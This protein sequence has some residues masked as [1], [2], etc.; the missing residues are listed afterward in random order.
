M[1]KPTRPQRLRYPASENDNNGPGWSKGIVRLGFEME[2]D[3]DYIVGQAGRL[4]ERLARSGGLRLS[5]DGSGYTAGFRLYPRNRKKGFITVTIQNN[6]FQGDMEYKVT[7]LGPGGKIVRTGRHYNFQNF[8]RE[9][10]DQV[11]CLDTLRKMAKS[12]IA[13]VAFRNLSLKGQGQLFKG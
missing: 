12:V 2:K 3:Y 5:K 8:R 11:D 9:L 1:G 6:E 10:E 7:L 4:V 13:R